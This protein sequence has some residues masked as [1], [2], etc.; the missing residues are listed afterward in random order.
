MYALESMWDC[1]HCYGP[2]WKDELP[3]K[4]EGSIHLCK[5]EWYHVLVLSL[6]DE[7]C[8]MPYRPS[9]HRAYN[10]AIKCQF[11]EQTEQLW[12]LYT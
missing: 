2:L 7:V 4:H 5:E 6:E 8:G 10:D 9:L 3:G 11:P 1:R 12:I